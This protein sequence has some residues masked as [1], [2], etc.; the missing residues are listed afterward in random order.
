M[1]DDEWFSPLV[2]EKKQ[3]KNGRVCVVLFDRIMLVLLRAAHRIFFFS[4][5]F[6]LL[7]EGVTERDVLPSRRIVP[8]PRRPFWPL[9]ATGG[10]WAFFLFF[11]L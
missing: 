9:N 5:L 7:S 2:G 11:L 4:F 8:R 3:K 1:V 10:S 6:S